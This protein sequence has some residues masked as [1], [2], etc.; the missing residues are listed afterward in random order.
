MWI[1]YLKIAWRN[2]LK[3]K[4]QSVISIMGLAVGM[5][6]F[7]VC[8]KRLA[9]ELLWNGRLEKSGETY[10]LVVR[11]TDGELVPVADREMAEAVRD[12]FPEVDDITLYYDMRGFTDKFCILKAPDGS[13]QGQ[14]KFFLYVDDNFIDFWKFRL[15]EGD[16]K[17]IKDLP[18]A[19]ILTPS[20]A[21]RLFGTID[22][23]GKTFLTG[24][25]FY[26]TYKNY[27]VIALMQEFPVCS[28]FEN[29][30]GVIL[31]PTNDKEKWE[32]YK[33]NTKVNLRLKPG[34]T[35]EAFN[36]KLTVY[37][38]KRS[39]RLKNDGYL[40]YQLVPL[41]QVRD[42]VLEEK[43]WIQPL[44]LAGMGYM[45]LLV[46]LLNYGLFLFGRI[47][48]RW[49][50]YQVRRF[51]GAS[52]KGFVGMF[53]METMLF[54]FFAMIFAMIFLELLLPFLT[55]SS[56]VNLSHEGA[57][58][59]LLWFG[60]QVF[61]V[62][63]IIWV[64][65]MLLCIWVYGRLCLGHLNYSMQIQSFLLGIQLI[66]CILFA[67]GSYF[68][69]A[70]QWYLQQ[71]MLG[72]LSFEECRRIYSFHFSE[73]IRDEFHYK[74]QGIPNIEAYCRTSYELLCPF[75]VPAANWKM[76]EVKNEQQEPLSFMY[77]DAGYADFIRAR[78]IEGRFF[79]GEDE[80]EVVVNQEFVRHFGIHP[81][82]KNIYFTYDRPMEV[83]HIVGVIEDVLPLLDQIK[84]TPTIYLPYTD[85]KDGH[86]FY[87]VKLH[88]GA[89]IETLIPLKELAAKNLIRGVSPNIFSLDES[90]NFRVG[91][92]REF[93][94]SLLL[95]AT[96]CLLG[97]YSSMMLA[98]EKR[99]REMAIRKINGASVKDIARIF[100][101]HYLIMVFASACIA[102]PIL[103]YIASRWLEN[104]D[105]RIDISPYVFVV[106]LAVL[107]LIVILILSSQ[108][109]RVMHV[110]PVKFLKDN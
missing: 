107:V 12:E 75:Y 7:V 73:N 1:H 14:R 104:Y 44:L 72:N 87:S 64:I 18:D 8:N 33:N 89:P 42:I 32:W 10:E 81:I 50:E 53:G 36:E 62:G 94:F 59:W 29:H 61:V 91:E 21:M 99:S 58:N 16:W 101:R 22:V 13:E 46:A 2:L 28:Q 71:K 30:A 84:I 74:V 47:L 17:T 88:S 24:D 93:G 70:Q 60:V 43:R 98:V 45:V 5:I 95:M 63:W 27:T 15:L 26:G 25:E 56:M 4:M 3:Y 76:P 108:L 40:S 103:Y 11:I 83:Y 92:I 68:M 67:G 78:M 66:V 6:C 55:E 34:V 79:T 38:G 37:D 110:N 106:I 100:L 90:I 57:R 19:V 9:D 65:M 51:A 20:S 54:L 109:L 39:E 69:Y 80:S 82:E 77:V 86:L 49:K 48:N 102:F 23:V 31:N 96:V 41:H 105:C 97:V 85:N 35:V 52:W